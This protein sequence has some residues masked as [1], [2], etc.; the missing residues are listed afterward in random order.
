M[1]PILNISE[2]DAIGG[3][4][5]RL[6][7]CEVLIRALCGGAYVVTSPVPSSFVLLAPHPMGDCCCGICFAVL[8]NGVKTSGDWDG[9]RLSFP[10]A[11]QQGMKLVAVCVI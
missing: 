9:Y 8:V 4:I 1:L 5:G 2:L 7:C 6:L 3:L 11:G 10:P